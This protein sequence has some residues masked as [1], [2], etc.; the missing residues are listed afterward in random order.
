MS[1]DHVST[2][3][4]IALDWGTSSL[5][6]WL[7]DASG[8]V[9]DERATADGIMQIADGDFEAV[10]ARVAGDWLAAHGA[11][12]ALACGMIGSRGGWVEAP[13]VTTPADPADLASRLTPVAVAGTTLHIVP[14]VNQAADAARLP[15]V[16]RGEESQVHGALAADPG[17]AEH[18]W[19][20]LPGTHC[21]WVEIEQGRIVGFKTFMTGELF[22]VLRAHSI[23]GRP[24]QDTTP[25]DDPAAF[26][27]GATTA[28]DTGVAGG[29][30]ALFSA[31]SRL[32]A[33][34]LQPASSLSYLSGLLIGEELRSVFA[35]RD[36]RPP[37][38]LIGDETL[39]ARYRTA[40]AHFDI[41]DTT[42]QPDAARYGLMR[43]ARAADL[44]Q[45]TPS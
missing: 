8:H 19:L 3:C 9:L 24:A 38:C 16:M 15:D 29:F 7:L 30:S 41:D 45:G 43:I 44:I 20:V 28:R 1:P 25:S 18:A 26:A 5:R 33:G 21:K 31:R 27:L 23:L 37:L 39:C 42:H 34:E 10:F 6:A 12:P 40:L 14:G 4:L 17:L 32:L 35:G 13:Y 11:L 2:A 36:D 22:A